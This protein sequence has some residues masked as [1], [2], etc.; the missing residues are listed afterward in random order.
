ML[1]LGELFSP[2]N[3][4]NHTRGKKLGQ[5]HYKMVARQLL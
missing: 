3:L 1:P 2:E 4:M 5:G